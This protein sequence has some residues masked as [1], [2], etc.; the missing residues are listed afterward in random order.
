MTLMTLRLIEIRY[1][2]NHLQFIQCELLCI[3]LWCANY[4]IIIFMMHLIPY[5]KFL[6]ARLASI[7]VALC[8]F[9]KYT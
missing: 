7:N 2:E 5:R 3:S 8:W 9:K 4:W 1:D 6:T